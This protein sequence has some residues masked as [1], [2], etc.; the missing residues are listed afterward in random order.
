M[1]KEAVLLLCLLF[2]FSSCKI[3]KEF[4]IAEESGDVIILNLD[5]SQFV[6]TSVPYKYD[7]LEPFLDTETMIIHHKKHHQVYTD[8]LNAALA[9]A[10]EIEAADHST[11]GKILNTIEDLLGNLNL[12][13]EEVKGAIRNHGGGYINHAF[14]WKSMI[15]SE[16][17][18]KV[19]SS[20][21][22]AIEKKFGS[23]DNFKKEFT[24]KATSLFGSGW[25]WLSF[26]QKTGEL[27]LESKSNQDSPLMEQNSL[28]LGLD[29]WEHAYYLKYHNKR[30]DYINAWWNV[31]N[32]E[33]VSRKYES[34]QRRFA[35]R[36]DEL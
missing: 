13:P 34:A 26:N 3:P 30:Q 24:D 28:I 15:P 32:W 33:F 4:S 29:V 2:Y 14:F 11:N 22:S 23:F 17:Q 16:T 7:A 36:K 1:K 35:A 18:G 10:R 20:L 12:V 27:I 8:K 25:A 9:R 21:Q 6:L 19:S 31:V 5:K